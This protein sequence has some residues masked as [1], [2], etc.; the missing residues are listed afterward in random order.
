MLTSQNAILNIELESPIEYY[1]FSVLSFNNP[2]PNNLIVDRIWPMLPA[3]QRPVKLFAFKMDGCQC[4]IYMRE[5]IWN[6]WR[7]T[8]TDTIPFPPDP[9]YSEYTLVSL[10]PSKPY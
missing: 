3:N 7:I 2:A 5:G 6:K 4:L 8:R 10:D 1:Y 9:L